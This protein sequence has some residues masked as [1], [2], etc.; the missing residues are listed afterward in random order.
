MKKIFVLL[1]VFSLL[2]SGCGGDDDFVKAPQSPCGDGVCDK[3]EKA[4][5]ICPE[6]CGG[7]LIEMGSESEELVIEYEEIAENEY[8]VT[9][10]TSGSKL[11]V[12]L[13]P[14][15]G[16][17]GPAP[18]IIMSPGGTG[19]SSAYTN[20]VPGVTSTAEKF[21][22]AGFNA[23]VYAPEGR[24]KS[25]G[26]EN[27]NGFIGQDGL[28][29]VTE[30]I[31]TL[32]EVGDI[33]YFTQSY[34]VVLAS[35]V[36]ARYPDG[37]AMFLIDWEGPVNRYDVTVGCKSDEMDIA[38]QESPTG[39]SCDDEEYWEERE[40]EVFGPEIEVP[41][42]RVQSLEDHVQP[43]ASNAIDMIMAT[44]N[45]KYGGNGKSPYTRLNDFEPN[46]IFSLDIEDELEEIDKEKYD[47]I[48]DYAEYLF[49][50]YGAT[51]SE[52]VDEQIVEE[53]EDYIREP[54]TVYFGF[55]VHLEGWKTEMDEEIKFNAH[56]D[57][58]RELADIFEANG[59]K[60]TFEAS[61]ETIEAC[62]NFENVLLEL[63]ERGHGIGVH[64]DA[65]NS[66]NPNYNLKLFTV[67]IM[68]MK[69]DLEALG[70]PVQHVSGTC[71]ELD[72]AKASIDAGYVFTTG[73]VGYCAMSMPEDMRPEVYSD[74]PYPGACHGNMPLD[75]EDR[76][77]PWRIS[78]AVGDW[79]IDDPNGK[80]VNLASDGG[81]KNLYEETLDPS[82]THG[83]MEYE[84]ED[85][86]VLVD[87]IEEAIALSDKNKVNIIYFSLSI[88]A[89]DVDT[90]FYQSMFDA[91][92][93]YVDAGQLEYKSMNEMY[94]E[95]IQWVN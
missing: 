65:G 79:T 5:G 78:T 63:Y 55:M 15:K 10:Q 25:E 66:S 16:V 35:G 28:Y 36:L 62:G 52:Q 11:Y 88:G 39:H 38:K 77:N 37:P 7:E 48:I 80:L 4:R 19:D 23:V 49:E 46:T 40:A 69:E 2:M 90:D 20:N 17:S 94:N 45:T 73:G 27:M 71:S 14:A 57:E 64:A 3:V 72:W 74:C 42:H 32:P 84:D 91:L 93:P 95:Y 33:G 47:M 8:Y 92:Q 31:D 82:Q 43:D 30:F 83:D 61:P 29:Y 51:D 53:D 22:N 89:K 60:V 9:N 6:D 41:Y 68:K 70:I 81:I 50:E 21:A 44:T 12:N 18:T 76:I 59:A 13:V 67:E 58:A 1:F 75:M 54:G 26:Q 86:D 85:I 87:K 24:G 34:G 56:M